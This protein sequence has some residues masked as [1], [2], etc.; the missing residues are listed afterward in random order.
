[1]RT[2]SWLFDCC[3]LHSLN[4]LTDF[5][6]RFILRRDLFGGDEVEVVPSSQGSRRGDGHDG[7]MLRKVGGGTIELVV[8][9]ASVSIKCHG[10]FDVY[11]KPLVDD[12]DGC[13]PLIQLHTCTSETIFFQMVRTSH[14]DNDNANDMHLD[15]LD[16]AI[17]PGGTM[18]M[19]TEK[20]TELTGWRNLS[21]RPAHYE[22]V[23][24]FVTPS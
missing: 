9:L 6:L 21:I 14:G 2:C 18:L 24:V 22:Q 23:D 8:R 17:T 20:E 12:A 11:P 7:R 5:V 13:E 4:H 3:R 15:P 19:L 16:T 1:M 10:T